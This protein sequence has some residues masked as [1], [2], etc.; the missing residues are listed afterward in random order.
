MFI[1]FTQNPEGLAPTMI[2]FL[3]E[4]NEKKNSYSSTKFLYAKCVYIT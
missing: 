1:A 4:I 3:F 2:K